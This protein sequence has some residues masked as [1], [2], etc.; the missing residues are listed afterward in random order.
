MGGNPRRRVHRDRDQAGIRRV[1]APARALVRRDGGGQDRGELQSRIR[2]TL[3]MAALQQVSAPASSP[4]QQ[5]RDGDR[6]TQSLYGP[7]S[8][9]FAGVTTME[10]IL[11]ESAMRSVPRIATA[12]S[13][14]SCPPPSRRRRAEPARGTRRYRLDPIS[15]VLDPW[16]RAISARPRCSSTR[17]SRT[18]SSPRARARAPARRRTPQRT[19]VESDAAESPRIRGSGSCSRS[20]GAVMSAR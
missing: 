10:P 8:R 15:V 18:A 16:M 6:T 4:P 20:P 17:C 2:G 19:N 11:L 5:E 3:L 14:R 13:P 7:S 1:P 9:L 12:G